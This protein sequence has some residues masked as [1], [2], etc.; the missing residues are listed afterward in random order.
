MEMTS[1]KELKAE[2][3]DNYNYHANSAY[4]TT[5][6]P[7]GIQIRSKIRKFKLH[8]RT[9]MNVEPIFDR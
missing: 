8:K 1:R 2:L 4:W 5:K 6:P 9:S 3:V 7:T